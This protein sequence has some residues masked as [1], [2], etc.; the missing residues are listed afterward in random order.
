MGGDRG[1]GRSPIPTIPNQKQRQKQSSQP[2]QGFQQP[3]DDED[4]EDGVDETSAPV[5]PSK[6]PSSK[7]LKQMA[8]YNNEVGTRDN[9]LSLTHTLAL[10]DKGY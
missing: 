3:D 10:I 1:G 6:S 7:N 9:A 4:D 5:V 8:A 2:V